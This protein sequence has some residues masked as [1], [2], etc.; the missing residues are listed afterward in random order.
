M[1]KKW[2][3]FDTKCILRTKLRYDIRCSVNS[4][5]LNI[6][7]R[8]VSAQQFPPGQFLARKKKPS[9]T[10]LS[11]T[12]HTRSS[13]KLPGHF[14]RGSLVGDARWRAARGETGWTVL[15]GGNI[16]GENYLEPQYAVYR[17]P[18]M[19]FFEQLY[20]TRSFFL[21]NKDILIWLGLY[22]K[23]KQ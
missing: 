19:N 1:L 4:L 2:K 18:F 21:I 5:P 13:K 7:L 10:L 8:T 3:F 20:F 23:K 14:S 9:R 12:L 6:P 22:W 11:R 15:G 17:F 16:R